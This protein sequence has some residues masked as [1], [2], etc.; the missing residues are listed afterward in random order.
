MRSRALTNGDGRPRRV[1][2]IFPDDS[3][4]NIDMRV[5]VQHSGQTVNF[6]V[7]GEHNNPQIVERVFREIDAGNFGAG[8][9]L[10]I[11]DRVSYNPRRADISYLKSAYLAAFAQLGYV[12]ILSGV[13]DKVRQQIQHPE[14]EILEVQRLQLRNGTTGH[15][16]FLVVEEPIHC[17]GVKVKDAVVLL[18]PF[19]PV[20]VD[21]FWD[22]IREVLQTMR[23]TK[24]TLK[25]V[26]VARWPKELRMSLDHSG[27]FK[28]TFTQNQP[29]A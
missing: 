14:D 23:T 20:V 10:Q 8:S 7:L 19:P 26:V 22:K 17:L 21:D 13:F 6:Q 11:R 18:P 25:P 15:D 9:T 12:Y 1:A 2:L 27:K 4:L 29:V 24:E 5:T 28:C 16:L 3:K